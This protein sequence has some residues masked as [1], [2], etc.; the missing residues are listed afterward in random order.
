MIVPVVKETIVSPLSA[1][2]VHTRLQTIVKRGRSTRWNPEEHLFMG[3]LKPNQFDISRILIRPENFMPRI[4]GRIEESSKGSIL[5][6]RYTLEFSTRMF[7]IFWSLSALFFALFL[8]FYETHLYMSIFALVALIANIL[9]THI[10]FHR[11]KTKSR[12]LLLSVLD[13]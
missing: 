1:E 9:I 5:F 11:H 10:N 6:L 2:E 12:K 13:L 7:Y 8:W 4:Q 3:K